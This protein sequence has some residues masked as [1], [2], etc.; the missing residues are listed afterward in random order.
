MLPVVPPTQKPTPEFGRKR[1]LSV[2]SKAAAIAALSAFFAILIVI[3]PAS[4]P[5]KKQGP[6]VKASNAAKPSAGGP[7]ASDYSD[8]HISDGKSR[9]PASQGM[10]TDALPPA[11]GRAGT[12]MQPNIPLIRDLASELERKQ[13]ASGGGQVATIA[14]SLIVSMIPVI[15]GQASYIVDKIG[16]H[17]S[18]PDLTAIVLELSRA[19]TAI[20][21]AIEGMGSFEEKLSSI[22]EILRTH[23]EI[24]NKARPLVEAAASTLDTHELN[25][26]GGLQQV[27]N[28]TF[29][30][31]QLVST[32]R[33]GGT[34]VFDGIN[35]EGP[36]R[37]DVEPGS[38]STTS[39]SAFV[40]RAPGVS[41]L[42]V[43]GRTPVTNHG[44]TVE[45]GVTRNGGTSA[46]RITATNRGAGAIG[47][48]VAPGSVEFGKK[49]DEE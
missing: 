41:T 19:I 46:T 33:G 31:L 25:N 5:S 26:N 22:T 1:S 8:H 17:L 34:S 45:H 11:E 42:S 28:S 4:P 39:N 48:S 10:S 15:G 43:Y 40:G 21:P 9:G 49:P 20:S 3:S 37:F 16:T 32:T 13:N 18:E 36:A 35:H 14:A 24:L 47:I 2:G 23:E 38:K 30:N 44:V 6:E 7:V 27:I 29:R 12:H